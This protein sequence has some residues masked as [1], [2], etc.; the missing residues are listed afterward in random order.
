MPHRAVVVLAAVAVSCVLASCG[1]TDI[2]SPRRTVTVTVDAPSAGSSGTSAA[3]PTPVP[4]ASAASV[5]IPTALAAGAQRG[6]PKSFDEA[7]GR[8]DAAKPAAGVG[9]RFQSPSGNIV[10]RRSTD[11][12]AAA[13]EVAQGRIPPPLP[14]ICHAGGPTDIGRIELG[15]SGAV[16]V[17]NSDTIRLGSEPKLAYGS[18]TEPAG[19]TACLSE[20][21]GVTCID[22]AGRHGFFLARDTFVTF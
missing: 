6:A 21:V 20:E 5:T 1:A 8:I 3:T 7:K 16:P 17:C 15:A 10:C 4:T 12:S 11:S 22:T 18:R 2:P 9:D 19:T 13:C 14:T